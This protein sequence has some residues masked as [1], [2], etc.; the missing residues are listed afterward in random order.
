MLKAK[1]DMFLQVLFCGSWWIC[2]IGANQKT[3]QTPQN[4]W[5]TG[6]FQ[7]DSRALKRI[8]KTCSSL[9]YS[10]CAR[11]ETPLR[12]FVIEEVHQ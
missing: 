3:Y 12:F 7:Q 2:R 6:V 11:V 10:I 5:Y 8:E 1:V 9:E 4:M